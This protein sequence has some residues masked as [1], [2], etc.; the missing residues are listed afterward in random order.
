MKA[1]TNRK[2]MKKYEAKLKIYDQHYDQNY[3]QQI[4][5][6]MKSD[7]SDESNSVQ[8]TIGLWKIKTKYDCITW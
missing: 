1:K 7:D 6:Q 8:M 4:I 2:S 5:T 3:D